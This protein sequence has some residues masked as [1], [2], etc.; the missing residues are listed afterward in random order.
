MMSVLQVD[1]GTVLRNANHSLRQTGSSCGRLGTRRLDRKF[2]DSKAGIQ[3][4][5]LRVRLKKC[6]I[7]LIWCYLCILKVI[8]DILLGKNE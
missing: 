5:R 4:F 7:F 1:I 6:E 3:A 8:F 2:P